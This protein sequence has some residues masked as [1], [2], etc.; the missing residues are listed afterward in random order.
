MTAFDR[1]FFATRQDQLP[2]LLRLEAEL[3][4]QYALMGMFESREPTVFAS[5]ADL[6][7]LGVVEDGHYMQTPCYMVLPKGKPI[8]IRT[9]PQKAGGVLYDVGLFINPTPISFRPSGRF[10]R[11]VI[12]PG[13]VD[14]KVGNKTS[15]ALAQ[16]FWQALTKGY[17][18]VGRYAIG[19]EARQFLE[20]GGRLTPADQCPPDMDVVLK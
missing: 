16:T 12:I 20:Q 17:V 7:D 9:V 19:P 3:K 6:P 2:G 11:Q 5:A 13:R 18:K 1:Q 8:Q 14:S 10:G 15:L 4:L